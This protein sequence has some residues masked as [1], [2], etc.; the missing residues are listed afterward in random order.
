VSE[1]SADVKDPRKAG[2]KPP[3]PAQS[4]EPP[5]SDAGLKPKADHGEQ[6]YR[7]CGRLTDR[8]ALITGADSGIGR[9][10][11]LAFAR[12]G[13]DVL[14]AYLNEDDDA[15]ET[16]R[17]VREAGRKAVRVPRDVRD[18]GHC[19]RLVERACDE[20]GRLDV[21]VNN[22]AFQMTHQNLDE[23]SSE[24]FDRTLETNLYALFYLCKAAIPRM[25]PGAA[26][27][28]TASIQGFDPSPFLLDYAT[29]KSGIIGFT[30]ALAKM[31]MK[32][33][34]AGERRRP[35]PGVDA[36]HPVHDAAGQ[37]RIVR[38]GHGPRPAGPAGGIG[39]GVRLPGVRR[40]QLRHRRS[41]RRHR[42]TDALLMRRRSPSGPSRERIAIVPGAR[43]PQPLESR[44][45]PRAVHRRRPA[46]H[47][48]GKRPWGD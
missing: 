39:P 25:H 10:V 41:L 23:F 30:K 13:A 44:P 43:Y 12:E 35:G 21:L 40:G 1:T 8:G 33:G 32:Q 28:N 42:G 14:I 34:G 24:Q 18:E 2:P 47:L 31:V 45:W 7:G 26:V 27:I 4:Q 11:A 5:G 38:Q 6:S 9:A 17:L 15:R 48:W 19:R 20:F 36:A 29:T 46:P 3:F 16:E 22:A 37:G